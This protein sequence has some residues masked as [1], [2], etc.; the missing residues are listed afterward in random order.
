[1]ST[2]NDIQWADKVEIAKRLND[3]VNQKGSQK[4]ASVHLNISNGTISK[5]LANEW[6]GISG[7][8][9]R[10][11]SAIVGR[12]TKQWAVLDEVSTTQKLLKLLDESQQLSMVFGITANAGSGKSQAIELFVNTHENAFSV[13][14][15]EY[16]E[17][18]DF[19]LEVFRSMGLEPNSTRV[20][21]MTRELINILKKTQ[22][23]VLILDEADKLKNRVLNFFITFYNDLE[24]I[25]GINL[26]A[27]SY[28]EK[29]I[30][31]GAQI[32]RKGFREI[33]SRLGK[34]FISLGDVNYSDVANICIANG[35][36][37]EE[38]ILKIFN[39][40]DNDLRRVKRRVIA[41]QRK[42]QTR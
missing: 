37:D 28:L 12:N 18:K 2:K 19:I 11:I 42:K 30:K 24:G 31:T 6:E 13:S 39:N 38:T 25:C 27:T 14:C 9:W 29:R 4:K 40:A 32:N 26:I 10:K 23:P 3:F 7:D 34:R 22:L 8:M 41:E 33:Y 35:V 20:Y 21:P 5:I 36:S 1:M 16:M 17:E 15:N